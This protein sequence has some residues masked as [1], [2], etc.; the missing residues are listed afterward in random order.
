MSILGYTKAGAD[1]AL[2]PISADWVTARAYKVG[3]FVISAGVPYRCNTVHT[4]GG[5]FDAS[6]FDLIG[7]GLSSAQLRLIECL[8]SYAGAVPLRTTGT[9][10]TL[11]P[12]R[13][14]GTLAPP[15]TAGYAITGLDVWDVLP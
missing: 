6:K 15:F 12:V 10:D 8:I 13:W 11:R 1:A 3:E 4:A 5:S 14:R 9:T 7:S 2:A